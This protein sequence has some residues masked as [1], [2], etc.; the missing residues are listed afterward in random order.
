MKSDPLEDIKKAVAVL[1]A[2]E[3]PPPTY[4]QAPVSVLLRLIEEHKWLKVAPEVTAGLK[5][6]FDAEGDVIVAM[7]ERE[8]EKSQEPKRP[9]GRAGGGRR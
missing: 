9:R 4:I 2:N 8:P 7:G 1:S 6:L 3:A 5:E